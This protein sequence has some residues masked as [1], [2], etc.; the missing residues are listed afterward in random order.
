MHRRLS[1][2]PL[3]RLNHAPDMTWSSTL[4]LARRGSKNSG[5]KAR[6]ASTTTVALTEQSLEPPEPLAQDSAHSSGNCS[7]GA[8]EDEDSV[9]AVRPSSDPLGT[10]V[11]VYARLFQVVT[12]TFQ[13]KVIR[14]FARCLV[15]FGHCRVCWL[16][17]TSPVREISVPASIFGYRW[18]RGVMG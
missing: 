3:F 1:H 7:S 9:D 2:P 8:G 15:P 17:H 18:S 14:L 5:S 10:G 4:G 11:R 12:D 16:V 13:V 6:R